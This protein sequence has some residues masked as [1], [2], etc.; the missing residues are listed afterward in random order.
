MIEPR[1]IDEALRRGDFA[2][3]THELLAAY[4]EELFGFLRAVGDDRRAARDAYHLVGERML[5]E[6][7]DFCGRCSLRTWIYALACRALSTEREKSKASA[8]GRSS[9]AASTAPFGPYRRAL[10]NVPAQLLASLPSVDRELLVL[11]VDR[12]L[13]WRDLAWT[14]IGDLASECRLRAEAA[15][16][17]R[18]FARIRL[19][20][21]RRAAR[22]RFSPS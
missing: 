20:L 1:A 3:A 15:R 11:R 5:R 9:I 8:S 17:R 14:T 16:L 6:L 22:L 10:T 21:L 7:P 4:G 2:R 12:L 19:D 13:S 18:R